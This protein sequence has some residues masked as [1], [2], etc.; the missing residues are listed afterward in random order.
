M[1]RLC[2]CLSLL[3]AACASSAPPSPTRGDAARGAL[4][5]DTACVRCHGEQVH[6]RDKHLVHSR[7][8]LLSQIRRW[9]SAAGQQWSEEEIADVAAYLE[10]RFYR[11]RE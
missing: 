1:R 9:Q 7:P 5:Y 10:S 2:A 3:L 4:L 6:W 8:E 11:F